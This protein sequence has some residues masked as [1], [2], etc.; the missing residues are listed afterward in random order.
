[1]QVVFFDTY[2][3]LLEFNTLKIY[4]STPEDGTAW[5]PLDFFARSQSSDRNVGMIMLTGQLWVF[6]G[7]TSQIFY[8]SG[9]PDNPFLPLPG[10]LFSEGATTPWAIGVLRDTVVW[11]AEDNQGYGR[12]LAA[13]SPSPQGDHDTGRRLRAR[14][15]R[16]LG[17]IRRCSATSRKGTHSPA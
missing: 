7:I 2:F 13:Q 16:E 1:M 5:D 10:S 3:L 12:V 11:L 14:A 4:Y 6:G 15:G 8:D 9:D 17:R